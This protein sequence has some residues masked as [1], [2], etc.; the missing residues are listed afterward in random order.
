M[1]RYKD[2]VSFLKYVCLGNWECLEIGLMV[3]SFWIIPH[4]F[5]DQ[6]KNT[7]T[8][9]SK[10]ILLDHNLQEKVAAI[11]SNFKPRSPGM[12]HVTNQSRCLSNKPNFRGPLSTTNVS[13]STFTS[14]TMATEKIHMCL[15]AK[16]QRPQSNCSEASG[17]MYDYLVR[18]SLPVSFGEPGKATT[19]DQADDHLEPTSRKFPSIT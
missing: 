14:T 16:V 19:C 4:T 7:G 8:L 5:V 3:R 12:S 11:M 1:Y 2:T 13:N 18:S 10:N 17:S 15:F 9:N 6:C